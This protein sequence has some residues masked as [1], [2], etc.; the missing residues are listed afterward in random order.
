MN[1]IETTY[2]YAKACQINFYA[3]QAD[4]AQRR[5]Q[6]G[7]EEATRWF[8]RFLSGETIAWSVFA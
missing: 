5:R 4:I 7:D 1:W 6:N 3:A 8:C 2:A